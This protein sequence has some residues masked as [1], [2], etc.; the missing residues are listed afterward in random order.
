[1]KKKLLIFS[2]GLMSM[3]LQAQ[4]TELKKWDA[5]ITG[6][7]T[8][9]DLYLQAPVCIDANGNTFT[10]GQFDH[11]ITIG[12][13]TLDPVANSAYLAKYLSDGT[14]AWA[15]SMS[16]A[17]T[18]TSVATDE[19]NNVYVAGIFTDVVVVGSTDGKTKEI[20]GVPENLEKTASFVAAYNANG[21]LLSVRSFMSK[22]D[23]DIAGSGLYS[24]QQVFNIE[25]IEA[26]NGKVYISA[27][28]NGDFTEDNMKW[29]GKYLNIFDF[30]Y[31]NLNSY[32]I[33]SLDA[34]T[35]NNAT[36]VAHID[37]AEQLQNIQMGPESLN[38][39]VENGNVYLCFVAN[40]TINYETGAKS[41]KITLNY[42]GDN[43]MIE[44][45][46][47]VS[48]I[49]GDAV[50]TKVFHAEAHQESAAYNHVGDMKVEGNNL[51]IGGTF[52]KS[53]AFDGTITHQ[54]GSDLF[55]AA[56]DKNTLDK[57]WAK[58]CGI[59]EG[60]G[61]YFSEKFNTMML[62]NGNVNVYGYVLHDQQGKK[63]ITAVQNLSFNNQGTSSLEETRLIG[64]SDSKNGTTALR[65]INQETFETT[66]SVTTTGNGIQD[67][68]ALTTQRMGNTFFFDKATDIQVYDL[69]GRMLKQDAKVTS[70]SI[71]DLP[72]GI[73]IL[74]N[75]TSSL[76][77]QK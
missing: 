23:A 38:F 76:K 52:L 4:N 55:V 37:V 50:N 57:E 32:G 44:H 6:V 65:S 45:A 12:Q 69:Q 48:S 21:E 54:G 22:A 72:Q 67:I 36:S 18:I 73:Y 41:E 25:H 49:K 59:N 17:A 70:I 10:T 31:D 5:N 66:L 34:E 19:N 64:A 1:M 7:S 11:S 27:I 60:D 2:L 30:M 13:T 74:T 77:V 8:A 15:I 47:I 16:G 68:P 14:A 33:F 46:Y 29:E 20:N 71:E 51:Y 42:N 56:L 26:S 43:G 35:L 63:E 62:D 75:G 40:G 9:K 3:T 39:T 58:A 53:L 61:K 28:H 24:G